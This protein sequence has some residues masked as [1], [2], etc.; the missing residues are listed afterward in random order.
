MNA[1]EAIIYC[2]GFVEDTPSDREYKSQTVYDKHGSPHWIA[3]PQLEKE[4]YFSAEIASTPRFC[5][6][7][8]C[9][10][11]KYLEPYRTSK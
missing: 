3:W 4:P 2:L 1:I 7:V 5:S 9:P 6:E 11:V 10:F 8:A